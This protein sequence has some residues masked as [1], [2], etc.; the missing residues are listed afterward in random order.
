MNE[1]GT[2]YQAC[3]LYGNGKM[4][5]TENGNKLRRDRSSHHYDTPGSCG[6]AAVRARGGGEEG[7][8]VFDG[9]EERKG[10]KG[11]DDMI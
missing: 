5:K 10:I 6:C 8:S 11:V 2:T 9:M 1:R 7:Q 3:T 4:E